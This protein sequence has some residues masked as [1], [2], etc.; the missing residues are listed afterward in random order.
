[1]QQWASGNDG[2]VKQ[3]TQFYNKKKYKRNYA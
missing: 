1:M 3:R 2:E